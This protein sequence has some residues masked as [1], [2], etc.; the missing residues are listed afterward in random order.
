MMNDPRTKVTI[1]G[2]A[3]ALALVAGAVLWFAPWSRDLKIDSQDTT[4][5]A[6]GRDVYLKQCASCHGKNLEGQPN[7][8]VRLPNGK[9]PAPPH[10]ASGHTWHH[11]DQQI[12]DITKDGLA[13]F[14]GPNYLTDMPKFEGTLS[15]EEIKAVIGFIK[16]TWPERERAAQ[17]RIE[18]PSI[19]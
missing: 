11:S 10:D 5:V 12:F 7:W 15:D 16:S 19:K 17:E 1:L 9:L 2:V 13:K 18:T 6:L 14:A 3:V 4:L 8:K